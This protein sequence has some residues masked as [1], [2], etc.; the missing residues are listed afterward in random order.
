MKAYKDH[1]EE[2]KAQLTSI[3]GFLSGRTDHSTSEVEKVTREVRRLN[4]HSQ[5]GLVLKI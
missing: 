5:E 3:Q 2:E 1:L 4:Y